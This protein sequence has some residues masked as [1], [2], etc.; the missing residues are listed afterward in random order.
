MSAKKINL[1]VVVILCAFFVSKTKAQTILTP[2]STYIISAKAGTGEARLAAAAVE[3]TDL[4]NYRLRSAHRKLTFD[5][6]VVVELLSAEELKKLGHKIDPLNYT[7]KLDE[8][9]VEPVYSVAPNGTL[10]QLFSKSSVSK[11]QT[12]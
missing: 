11:S 4:S 5:T 6:G 10:M 2:S 3:K 12:R 8:K 9:Y 7:E 1:F